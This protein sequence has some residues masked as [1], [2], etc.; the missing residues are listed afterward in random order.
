L[1]YRSTRDRSAPVEFGD[2][3]LA[4]PAPDGG[5]YVPSSWPKIPAQELARYGDR[6]Y[7]ETVA[8]VVAPFV[9]PTFTADE[10]G[11]LAERAYS[12]F[13]H[14]EVAPLTALGG[15]EWLLEL[16]WGPTLSFK[17]YAM[18]LLGALF[19]E[20]LRRGSRPVTVVGATSGDTGSAAMAALA[21]REGVQV[22]ILFPR[23]RVS[24]VQRRQ[25]TTI[26]AP[27]VHAVAIAGSF[28]DCQ[29]LV[30]GLFADADHAARIGLAAV[31]SI[32]WARIVAQMAFSAWAASRLGIA[33]GG[34]ALSI[35][36]GNFGNVYAQYAGSRIGVPLRRLIVGSNRNHG[37]TSLIQRGTLEIETVA[38]TLSP[39]MDIQIPS[40][41]ERLLAE[42]LGGPGDRVAR[43]VRELRA[44]GRLVLPEAAHASVSEMFAA[45]WLDDDSTKEMIARVHGETGVLVDPHTAIGIAAGR[46]NRP[47]GTPL[48]CLAT[49]HPA[50]FPEAVSEATGIAPQ[51]P[52]DLADLLARPERVDLVPAEPAAVREYIEQTAAGE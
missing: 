28:D 35:P 12:G 37:V 8:R 20:T 10:I 31:N 24:E 11:V 18:A 19:E 2:L 42:M 23:G 34:M 45:T 43:A 21:G 26:D 49:A 3:L 51:L 39:A 1:R 50:K 30:K 36:T 17:D 46:A 4:G 52:A 13:R 33:G 16:T 25:M 6:P 9:A 14:R 40:N 7:F 29:D 44:T 27:N 48:V 32:N 15:D 41:L 38:A 5:L 47:L 22:V